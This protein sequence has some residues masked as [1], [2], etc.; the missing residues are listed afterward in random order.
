MDRKLLW[1]MSIGA[2]V[3]V[4]NLYYIQPLLATIAQ[5]FHVS[6]SAAGSL[7]TITQAGYAMGM[8]LLV[9]L[10][11]AVEKRKLILIMLAL[12]G[13]S[14]LAM[15]GA[16]GLR[17]LMAAS[18]LIGIT[19]VTPQLIVPF[20]AQLAAE[21]ERGKVVGTV[22]SGLFVGILLARTFS[23]LVASRFG[24][25]MVYLLAAVLTLALMIAFRS[26]L[27]R[28]EAGNQQLKYV[29][30]LRSL[31]GLLRE[32]P[33]LRS[34]AFFGAMG[35][36][37]FSGFWTVLP[38]RLAEP[39]YGF[40]PGIVGLFAL[41]GVTGVVVAPLAGR[42]ADRGKSRMTIGCGLSA[43]LLAYTGMAF[44]SA[45]I[46][47]L[48]PGLI[49][50]DLGTTATHISNQARV[51]SVRPDARNRMTTVYMFLYFCGG[52]AGSL[53]GVLGW[54]RG[55][56]AGFCVAAGSFAVAG[57]AVY[58]VTRDPLACATSCA[59]R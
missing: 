56:W 19:T 23:G 29:E 16:P 28:G 6:T 8:L 40:G 34:S 54:T 43:I 30:L 33:M 15:A 45:N 18:L 48:I 31:V 20:A 38:F 10:G 44:S 55:G 57:L 7:A 37:A 5:G 41:L 49:L 2:G 4:A 22:M 13:C 32:E 26:L 42:L 27:P 24:W 9:P 36:G 59:K 3:S 50:L 52:P 12:V 51:Y 58:G 11:D 35:F 53:I 46:A 1:T 14:L 47:V 39:P 25:R 21:H 17:W